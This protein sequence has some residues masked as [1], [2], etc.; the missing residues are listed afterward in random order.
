M[1][2]RRVGHLGS[3]LHLVAQPGLQ[4]DELVDV[5]R[6]AGALAVR[7]DGDERQLEIA[8]QGGAAAPDEVLVEGNREVGNCTRAQHRVPLGAV[9]L[10]AV[11]TKLAGAGLLGP[12]LATQVAQREVAEVE[13]QLAWKGEIGRQGRVGGD[14]SHRHAARPEGEHRP[15]QIMEGLAHRGI[16]EPVPQRGLVLGQEGDEIDVRG[17]ACARLALRRRLGSDP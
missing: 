1:P 13:A 16:G 8:Q 4:L 10:G 7:Q 11:E 9:V 3:V 17:V 15:L 5:G 6:D 2:D 14:A 12:E